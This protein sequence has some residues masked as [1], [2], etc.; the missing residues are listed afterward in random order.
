L[1]APADELSD[2]PILYIAG[3]EA[4]HFS[5]EHAA[6]VKQFVQS[7][8]LVLASADCAAAE[9]STSFKE[10][11]KKMFPAYEFAPLPDNHPI[12]TNQQFLASKWKKKPTV[13]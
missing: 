11:G 1:A 10:L 6:K 9:F 13:L 7:G 5:D 2:A 12:F 3:N 4:L 8:G